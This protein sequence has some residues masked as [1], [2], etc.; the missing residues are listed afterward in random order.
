MKFDPSTHCSAKLK[1]AAGLS[2]ILEE[3][4]N[5]HFVGKINTILSKYN[6]KLKEIAKSNIENKLSYF[7]MLLFHTRETIKLCN[8]PT[9]IES[10]LLN[11]VQA[12]YRK[13]VLNKGK[14][15]K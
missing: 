6:V 2:Q 5:V 9:K 3:P 11:I 12:F 7:N 14:K 10:H 15:G 8:Y 13:I 1:A 4:E